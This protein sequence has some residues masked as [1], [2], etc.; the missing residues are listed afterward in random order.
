MTRALQA[1]WRR[2]VQQRAYR[3]RLQFLY[4]NWRAVVKV[5][6]SRDPTE[7]EVTGRRGRSLCDDVSLFPQIQSLVKMWLQRRKYRARLAFFRR[8]VSPDLRP[9]TCH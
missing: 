6:R 4:T 3:Q 5:T 1:Q 9:L 8:H 7:Q 2:F